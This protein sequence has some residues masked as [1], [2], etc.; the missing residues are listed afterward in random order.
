M[1]VRCTGAGERRGCRESDARKT[2]VIGLA[3]AFGLAVGMVPALLQLLKQGTRVA[4]GTSFVL[5]TLTTS[6]RAERST[7]VFH[8]DH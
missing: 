3:P 1:H 2:L 7:I 8:F 4:L 5:G 6:C